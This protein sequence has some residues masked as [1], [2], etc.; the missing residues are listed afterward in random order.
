MAKTRHKGELTCVVCG[1]MRYKELSGRYGRWGN[2]PYCPEAPYLVADTPNPGGCTQNCRSG[3]I[4]GPDIALVRCP[5]G[6]AP[7]FT[8]EELNTSR[9]G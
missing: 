4:P 7:V 9:L 5:C 8:A 1:S 3:W 2:G 6:A